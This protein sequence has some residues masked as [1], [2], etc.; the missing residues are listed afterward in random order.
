MSSIGPV[1]ESVKSIRFE[2]VIS[3]LEYTVQAVGD[4][5]WVYLRVNEIRALKS[6]S[7]LVFDPGFVDP[8]RARRM[9]GVIDA[10]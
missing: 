5:A 3:L 1:S 7:T 9:G 10:V 2:T 6:C 8:Q 4:V